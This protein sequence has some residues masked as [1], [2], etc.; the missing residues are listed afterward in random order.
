MPDASIVQLGFRVHVEFINLIFI[1]RFI[2]KTVKIC[3]L[4]NNGIVSRCHSIDLFQVFIGI[5]I[6]PPFGDFYAFKTRLL[7]LDDI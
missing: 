3:P 4:N 7:K 5:F 1:F 6:G 2:F